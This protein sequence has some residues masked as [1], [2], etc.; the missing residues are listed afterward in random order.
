MEASLLRAQVEI[1]LKDQLEKKVLNF[2]D[3]WLILGVYEQEEK[4]SARGSHESVKTKWMDHIAPR[5][6]GIG[7]GVSGFSAR[8]AAKCSTYLEG[9]GNGY[10]YLTRHG[11][12][13]VQ[14]LKDTFPELFESHLN[15]YHEVE[16]HQG[17]KFPE[18]RWRLWKD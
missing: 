6:R 9:S 11:D 17:D 5:A 8:T 15:C 13:V 18:P 14:W 4:A 3:L 12:A 1:T 2:R 10:I 16:L 7:H